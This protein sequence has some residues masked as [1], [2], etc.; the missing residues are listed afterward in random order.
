MIYGNF[1]VGLELETP[2]N[3]DEREASTHGPNGGNLAECQAEA[4]C[5]VHTD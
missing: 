2:S 3:Q 1:I 4:H 5:Y